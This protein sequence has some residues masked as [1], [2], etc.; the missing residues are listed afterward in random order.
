MKNRGF[1]QSPF[2]LAFSTFFSTRFSQQVNSLSV[3]YSVISRMSL[4]ISSSKSGLDSIFFSTFFS[5][6]RMVE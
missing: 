3:N 1:F 4:V 6:E 5:A 2:F